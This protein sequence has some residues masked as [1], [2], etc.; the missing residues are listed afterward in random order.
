[1]E[2]LPHS[3]LTARISYGALRAAE[4][5]RQPQTLCCVDSFCKTLYLNSPGKPCRCVAQNNESLLNSPGK[6]CRRVAQNN[7][8]LYPQTG[9]NDRS[10]VAP[11]F[12]LQAFHVT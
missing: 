10:N 5:A 1:M 4:V 3:R 11:N 7:E 12:G 6:P 2:D 9:P 8:S